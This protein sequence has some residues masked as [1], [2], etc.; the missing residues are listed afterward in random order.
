MLRGVE[1]GMVGHI[2]QRKLLPVIEFR[3]MCEQR[4]IPSGDYGAITRGVGGTG[5]STPH[6]AR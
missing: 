5:M 6:N 2:T 4:H 3:P 1:R